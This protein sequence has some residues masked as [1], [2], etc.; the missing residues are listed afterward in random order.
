ML[1]YDKKQM[2]MKETLYIKKLNVSFIVQ[3]IFAEFF[4][5]FRL[6]FI[7][8]FFWQHV[9]FF[10]GFEFWIIGKKDDILHKKCFKCFWVH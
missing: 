5:F 9:R 1:K 3:Q 10:L 2:N 6:G 7:C 8:R 4:M